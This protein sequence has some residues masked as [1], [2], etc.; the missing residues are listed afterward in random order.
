[1]YGDRVD[2]WLSARRTLLP[3]PELRRLFANAYTDH[4]G[5]SD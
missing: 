2:R 5:L 3:T 1:M 4:A